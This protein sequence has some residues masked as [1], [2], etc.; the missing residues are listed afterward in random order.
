MQLN[1]LFTEMA[2][3][4]RTKEETTDKI[5]A[6]SFPQRIKDLKVLDTMDATATANDIVAG[7]IAY[8]NGKRVIGTV[9][10]NGKLE[11]TPSDEEQIIPAGKISGGVVKAIETEDLEVTPSDEEQKFNGLFKNVIVKAG[12]GGIDTSDATATAED[13]LKDK[14]AYVNGEKV[15]GTLEVSGGG[16]SEIIVSPTEPTG[17]NRKAIWLQKGKN[18]LY[19]DF[20]QGSFYHTNVPTQ[21]TK[22]GDY[23]VKAGKNYTFS[24][25]LSSTYEVAIRVHK[26]KPPTND[27]NGDAVTYNSSWIK[28]TGSK[29]LSFT[30][31]Q[32]G[33]LT[34]EARRADQTD[35]WN[36][37][38]IDNLSE[39]MYINNNFWFQLE[40]GDTATEYEPY[41]KPK[42]YMLNENNEY[43]EV[44]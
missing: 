33:Y 4:L 11:Y 18:L 36:Y 5:S 42:L 19:T 7:K 22:Y 10:D 1:E 26:S 32:D 31:N 40:E 3:A 43:V 15:V 20:S 34:V 12:P 16:D 44:K 2:E 28:G 14:T 39:V 30:P 23:K 24:T 25:N 29:T 21:A 35:F 38:K 13:I 6:E 41:I 9:I 8:A 17:A 27:P 37:W